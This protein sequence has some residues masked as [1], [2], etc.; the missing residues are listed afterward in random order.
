MRH[1]EYCTRRP[2]APVRA[3]YHQVT[4][5]QAFAHAD[6]VPTFSALQDKLHRRKQ[7]SFPPVPRRSQDVTVAGKWAVT[8]NDCRHLVALDNGWS[9]ALFCTD[10]NAH[11]LYQCDCIFIDGTVR[12]APRPYTQWSLFM[13]FLETTS[14]PSVSVCWPAR[15]WDTT[16]SYFSGFVTSCMHCTCT[17]GIHRR[18]CVTLKL[19]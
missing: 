2:C 4:G 17:A 15:Q 8:W 7:Q 13:D 19:L 5:N 18:S 16:G 14:S 3:A 11:I 6:D 12:L 9:L 1:V 10:K